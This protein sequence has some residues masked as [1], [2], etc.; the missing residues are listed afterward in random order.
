MGILNIKKLT[1]LICIVLAI[2]AVLFIARHK[3]PIIAQPVITRPVPYESDGLPARVGNNFIFDYAS[4]MEDDANSLDTALR[5]ITAD[6]KVEMIVV[7]VDQTAPLS[8]KEFSSQLFEKWQIGSRFNGRG[9]LFVIAKQENISRIH[10]SYDLEWIFTDLICTIIQDRQMQPWLDIHAPEIAISDTILF[11]GKLISEAEDNGQLNAGNSAS[12]TES[13]HSGGAG[14]Q[15]KEIFSGILSEKQYLS[16]EQ[17]LLFPAGQSPEETLAH[18]IT[19]LGTG[20]TDPTLD[21]YTDA[22][23][24]LFQQEAMLTYEYKEYLQTLT[25]SSFSKHVQGDHAVLLPI[26]QQKKS[27]PLLF[28]RNTQGWQ[29]DW[30]A[31]LRCF[32]VTTDG[33]WVLAVGLQPYYFGLQQWPL[34]A[35]DSI[36]WAE[37]WRWKPAEDLNLGKEITRL[38]LRIE[39][40]QATAAELTELAEILLYCWHWKKALSLFKAAAEKNPTLDNWY[41]VG[42]TNISMHRYATAFKAYKIAADKVGGLTSPRGQGYLQTLGYCKMR[43]RYYEEAL[44][45]FDALYKLS[46]DNDNI[47]DESWALFARAAIY[48]VTNQERRKRKALAAYHKITNEN[49]SDARLLTF[50]KSN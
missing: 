14:S 47:K 7:T 48:K 43:L 33:Q 1:L 42:M 15:Q 4:L 6:H 25:S 34:I 16:D 50:A 45:F 22:S 46:R 23:K 9:L 18:F 38:N 8:V 31:F 29:L 49:V 39:N 2:C 27:F 21:I 11:A 24:I 28:T 41:K 20:V 44:V 26:Q 13:Y 32:R 30:A 36:L 37:T 19:V 3:K 40:G 5:K 12:A 17:R 35:E 10:V